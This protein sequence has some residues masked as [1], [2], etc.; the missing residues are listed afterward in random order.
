LGD[1]TA[2][3]SVPLRKFCATNQRLGL[4]AHRHTAGTRGG[5]A[6]RKRCRN[7]GV[8]GGELG[9]KIPPNFFT[10]SCVCGW[11]LRP[12]YWQCPAWK[13]AANTRRPTFRD[14]SASVPCRTSAKPRIA[15][16]YQA[17]ALRAGQRK[18]DGSKNLAKFEHF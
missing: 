4:R 16:G 1:E 9:E 7:S 15:F 14:D 3:F 10:S 17:F 2:K 5:S 18:V 8:A 6:D 12:D 13:F 11:F